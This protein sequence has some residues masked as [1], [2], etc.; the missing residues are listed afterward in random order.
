MADTSELLRLCDEVERESFTDHGAVYWFTNAT[1]LA[2]FLKSRL[3]AEAQAPTTAAS[4]LTE[5]ERHIVQ[6]VRNV[7]NG[8]CPSVI[9]DHQARHLLRIIDRLTVGAPAPA[10]TPARL[11]SE[12]MSEYK[13]GTEGDTP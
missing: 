6:F 12:Y 5:D 3:Q 13:N 11:K 7:V 10:P 2:Y 8:P 4:V 9:A 1:K